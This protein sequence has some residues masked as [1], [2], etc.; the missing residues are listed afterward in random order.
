MRPDRGGH[1][2][3]LLPTGEEPGAGPRVGST[4]CG[5][6]MWAVKN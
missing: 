2:A 6:R 5:L 3:A 4:V 1:K